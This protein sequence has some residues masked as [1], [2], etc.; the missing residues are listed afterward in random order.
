MDEPLIPPSRVVRSA[1]IGLYSGVSRE[2]GNLQRATVT[3]MLH[4]TPLYRLGLAVAVLNLP[5]GYLRAGTQRF[6]RPW[7]FAVHAPVPVVIAMRILAGIAWK[8][9]NL[10]VL[11][12]AFFLGQFL[13][14]RVRL[15]VTRSQ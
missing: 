11:M 3:T 5:F 10:P 12:G 15:L 2:S 14:G 1:D 8:L 4:V 7:F 9:A 6:T 13:G